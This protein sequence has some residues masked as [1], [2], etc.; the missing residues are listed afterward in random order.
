MLVKRT[1]KV[2]SKIPDSSMADIAF[3][4]IIFF[5]VTTTFSKDKTTVNLPATKERVES[6]KTG[7]IISVQRDGALTM[8]GK[9]AQMADIAPVAAGELQTNSEK[10][11]IIKSDK[12]ARY[13]HVDMVLDQLRAAKAKNISLLTE[14]EVN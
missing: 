3:L 1:S 2:E 6:P 13:R 7:V 10:Y 11:F 4:L 9:P 12:E 5:M 8:D 14:Q